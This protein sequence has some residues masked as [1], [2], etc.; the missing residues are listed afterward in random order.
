MYFFAFLCGRGGESIGLIGRIG[1]IG[2]MGMGLFDWAHRA[3]RAHRRYGDGTASMA[4][5]GDEHGGMGVCGWREM[6]VR[7]V[8]FE[9]MSREYCVFRGRGARVPSGEA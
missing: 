7:M 9:G 2:G 4:D 8:D 1:L 6:R 5:G 3:N